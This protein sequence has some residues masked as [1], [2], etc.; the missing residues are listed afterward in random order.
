MMPYRRLVV[1]VALVL[2]AACALRVGSTTGPAL[3]LGPRG[4]CGRR[5]A[6]V[7]P[8]R[9]GAARAAWSDLR[10]S[11]SRGHAAGSAAERTRARP[12]HGTRGR[13]GHCSPPRRSRG[14]ERRVLSS[15]R[16]SRWGPQDRWRAGQRPRPNETARSSCDRREGVRPAAAAGVRPAVG[17]GLAVVR[18]S[19]P[20]THGF[21]RRHRHDATSA[22]R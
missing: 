12:G 17:H 13:G 14:R 4:P 8:R 20:A 16:R 18:G 6:V 3:D 19:R 1:S 15:V 7:S 21:H 22:G 2:S 10:A 5:C 9:S 11:A